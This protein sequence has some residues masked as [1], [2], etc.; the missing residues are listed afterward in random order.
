[1][2]K[3]GY[4]NS[5]SKL[6]IVFMGKIVI[7]GSSIMYFRAVTIFILFQTGGIRDDKKIILIAKCNVS[8]IYTTAPC[9][10]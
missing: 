10:L 6:I 4:L 1:M 5:T 2:T 9:Y 8:F 7:N 3:K